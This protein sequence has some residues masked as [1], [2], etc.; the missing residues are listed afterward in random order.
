MSSGHKGFWHNIGLS[1]STRHLY[2]D[3]VWGL[4][5]MVVLLVGPER[6]AFAVEMLR[7][8]FCFP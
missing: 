1:N 6:H 2:S 4:L 7:G 8:L 5:I 3:F